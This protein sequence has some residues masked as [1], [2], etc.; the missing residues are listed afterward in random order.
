M[1]DPT[2]DRTIGGLPK[3]GSAPDLSAMLARNRAAEPPAGD[4]LD[5]GASKDAAPATEAPRTVK[6]AAKQAAT[7][8][9]TPRKMS[10]SADT[11]KTQVT[12]YMSHE[13]RNRARAA[14]KATAHLEGDASWSAFI[15]QAVLTETQRREQLYNDG[16]EYAGGE[17]ALAPGRPIR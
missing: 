10:A 4:S 11:G 14:F 2:P 17:R 16:Q 5:G 6:K 9:T 13:V 7:P 12:A 8:R 15:E 3:R 1:S